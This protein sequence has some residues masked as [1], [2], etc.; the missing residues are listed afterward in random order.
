MESQLSI[1][2][3]PDLPLEVD[4]IHLPEGGT[5]KKRQFGISNDIAWVVTAALIFGAVISWVS[6]LQSLVRAHFE[7]R[8][9]FG[10]P[11]ERE[12]IEILV[13]ETFIVSITLTLIT[14]FVILV[15]QTSVAK[16]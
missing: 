14:I 12:R 11:S 4:D 9:K 1:A 3:I 15:L 6:V 10:V 7:R 13:P 16:R 5:R 2:P 8:R